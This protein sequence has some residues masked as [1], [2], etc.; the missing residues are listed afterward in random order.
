M[1][2]LQITLGVTTVVAV[3]HTYTKAMVSVRG[4][5]QISDHISV[6]VAIGHH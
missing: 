1:C 5:Y 2:S 6:A 3:L 4:A